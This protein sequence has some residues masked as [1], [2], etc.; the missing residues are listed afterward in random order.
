MSPASLATPHATVFLATLVLAGYSARHGVYPPNLR[1]HV[2]LRQ[3]PVARSTASYAIPLAWRGWDDDGVIDH[4]L[5]TVD[6]IDTVWTSTKAHETVATFGATT[7]ADST[8]FADWHTFY[9]KAIDNQGAASEPATLT[10]NASTIAPV[11]TPVKPVQLASGGGINSPISGGKTLRLEWTGDDP[12][13]VH[14]LR[15]VAY[16]IIRV[17]LARNIA[18]DWEEARKQAQGPGA[19]ILRVGSATSTISFSDLAPGGRGVNWM[20]WV[21]AIDEAG[22][23]EQWPTRPGSWPSFFFF[24]FALP[25][26]QGPTMTL[27]SYAFGRFEVQGADRDSFDYAFDAPFSVRFNA[28][29]T[30]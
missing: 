25:N 14:S 12:D 19:Q 17:P 11:T 28:D 16:E 15:P 13:G 26:V 9:V 3:G 27:S 20:F 22:A 10:F 1:P 5:Y 6:T 18:G 30:T 4:Y 23:E 29:A 7:R 8:L 21:C 2:A 24:Y